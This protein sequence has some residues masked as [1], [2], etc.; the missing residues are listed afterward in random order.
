MPSRTQRV[1]INK[2]QSAK[3]MTTAARLY[4]KPLPAAGHQ[5]SQSSNNYTSFVDPSKSQLVPP[6]NSK[7]LRF[8]GKLELKEYFNKEAGP[9]TY[10]ENASTVESSLQSEMSKLRDI[11]GNIQQKQ[12]N[13]K[14]TRFQPTSEM[15]H[16]DPRINVGPGQYQ[17]TQPQHHVPGPRMDYKGDFSLPFNENNPLNYVKPITVNIYFKQKTPGV[18]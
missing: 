6:F 4:K 7:D 16:T 17:P 1:L 11:R 8:D 18:G 3:S 10:S 5:T 13:N 14:A 15:L 12:F 9:G 2:R